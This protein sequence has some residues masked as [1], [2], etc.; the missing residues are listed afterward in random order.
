MLQR[1]ACYNRPMAKKVILLTGCSSG[2]G[3]HCARML[4][5]QPHWQVFAS[6]RRTEDVARLQE[7]GLTALH[8]D[9]NDSANIHSAVAQMLQQSGGRIDALFNN[10]AYGQMG[11]AEDLP[12][13]ALRAQ[14]ETNVFGTQELTNLLLPTMRKQ[15]SGRII[16][17]SSVLGFVSLRYRAAYNASK[18]ALE[19]LSDTMRQELAGSGVHIVLIEPGPIRS[20][21]RRN[22]IRNLRARIDEETIAASAHATHYRRALQA[23]APPPSDPPFTLG[24]E[25]VYR[26]LLHALE[27]KRPR[28]RYRVTVPTHLFWW[29][30]RLLPTRALDAL[31]RR[32]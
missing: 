22:A 27:A 20:D 16:Q 17:N 5:R 9:L 11:A 13:A 29:G 2:I 1:R 28:A 21:F 7:E 31:L 14:F 8:L 24:P 23:D 4:H 32:V 19:G 3:L 26:A 10:G 18:Y 15:G 12:R 6:A 25:A 30:K